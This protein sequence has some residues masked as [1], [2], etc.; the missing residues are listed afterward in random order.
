MK[1][2]YAK[3][4]RG[5]K[6]CLLMAMLIFAGLVKAGVPTDYTFTSFDLPAQT[7][8]RTFLT[9]YQSRLADPRLPARA[10][11]LGPSVYAVHGTILYPQDP[12][13]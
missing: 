11:R 7:Y 8:E 9:A 3:N 10:A 1:S 6:A 5:S 2:W 4:S 13:R 12:P